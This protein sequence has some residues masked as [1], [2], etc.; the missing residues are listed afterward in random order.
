MAES[1]YAMNTEEVADARIAS[2]TEERDLSYFTTE[3]LAKVFD[4]VDSTG[5]GRLDQGDL[6]F[7]LTIMH[8]QPD[9]KELA[10]MCKYMKNSQP[11][12]M[13]PEQIVKEGPQFDKATWV[14]AWCDP[15]VMELVATW[16]PGAGGSTGEE[17][18]EKAGETAVGEIGINKIMV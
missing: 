13:D 5:F 7:V 11:S 12:T 4:I 1:M 18:G 2:L 3:P 6:E 9:E 16:G 10:V 17:A 14:E 15:V 8:L